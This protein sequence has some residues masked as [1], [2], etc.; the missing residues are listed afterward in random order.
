MRYG[1][2]TLIKVGWFG[3]VTRQYRLDDVDAKTGILVPGWETAKH[4]LDHFLL[5]VGVSQAVT[6]Q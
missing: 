6:K 1:F 3:W 5:N 2:H 4:K